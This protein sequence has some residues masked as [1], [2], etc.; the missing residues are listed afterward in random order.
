M[1]KRKQM[2]CIFDID[3]RICRQEA[4]WTGATPKDVANDLGV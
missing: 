4:E 3:K 2:L 1:P